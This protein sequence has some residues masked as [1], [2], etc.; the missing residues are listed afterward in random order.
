L[1]VLDAQKRPGLER[2]VDLEQSVLDGNQRPYR[3]K[4]VY[5]TGAFD[6]D[7]EVYRRKGL[8]IPPHL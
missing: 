6:I 5:P 1:L 8:I 4:E 7:I 3:I 2:V